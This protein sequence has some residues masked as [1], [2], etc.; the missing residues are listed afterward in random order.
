MAS[1]THQCPHCGT[2][3]MHFPVQGW[4]QVP[5]IADRWC[6]FSVCSSCQGPVCFAVIGS[7]PQNFP[8]DL[9]RVPNKYQLFLFPELEKT[10]VPEHVPDSA[11][12]AFRQAVESRKAGHYDAAGAMYRKT[13]DVAL[14]RIDAQ[15]KGLL[16][17]RIDKLASAN[18]LTPSIKDWAHEIRLDG[19]DASHDEDPFTKPEAE[20]MHLF[21]QLLLTYLFTL[22]ERVKLRGKPKA[23]NP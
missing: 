14:K 5:T 17:D 3:D 19:N 9:I 10:E 2:K 21:A 13:L 8:G 15:L 11:A 4:Y 20:Q 18:K 6:G 22:P 1:L 7:N 12:N 16:R 23:D